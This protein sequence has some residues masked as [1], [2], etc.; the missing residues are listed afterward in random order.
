M[1]EK[2]RVESMSL[3]KTAGGGLIGLLIG[4]IGGPLGMLIGS[5]SGL[6]LGSLF[7]LGDA[8]ETEWALGAISSSVLQVGCTSL[9]VVVT[10]P[11]PSCSGT[12]LRRSVA[13]VEAE[14]AAAEDA[15]REAKSEARKELARSHREHDKAAVDTKLDQ[16]KAKLSRGQKPPA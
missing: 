10:E 5:A 6:F 3:S 13:D 8:E 11:N 4:I 9:L 14:M 12:V 15:E 16:L 1:V 7:D 2:D